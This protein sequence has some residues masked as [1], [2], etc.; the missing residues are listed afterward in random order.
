MEPI[1]SIAMLGQIIGLHTIKK[2]STTKYCANLAETLH[3]LM[4]A[5]LQDADG[6]NR[7]FRELNPRSYDAFLKEYSKEPFD[8]DSLAYYL[9]VLTSQNN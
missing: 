8:K 4:R 6:L 7:L 5:E 9:S 3:L 2:F 1:D